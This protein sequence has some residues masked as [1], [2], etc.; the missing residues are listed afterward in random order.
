MSLVH[1]NVVLIN[2]NPH[3]SVSVCTLVDAGAIEVIFT[4]TAEL[5]GD[6][7]PTLAVASD[8]VCEP[9][10]TTAGGS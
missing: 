6:L 1:A 5:G 10:E 2:I 3:K 7:Q 9:V 8:A 4:P